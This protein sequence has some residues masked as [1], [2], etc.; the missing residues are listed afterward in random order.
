MIISND[1]TQMVDF[2][3]RIPDCDSRSSALLDDFFL[4]TLVFVLQW[5]C[6]RREIQIM[7]FTDFPSDSKR[8][9]PFHRIAYDYSRSDWDNRRDYLRDVSWK[10]IF[11]VGAF[12]AASAKS[13]FSFAQKG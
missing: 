7:L 11:Q 4:L 10:D 2:P 8:D 12:A 13:L 6:L 3:T 5:L 9:A 1:L